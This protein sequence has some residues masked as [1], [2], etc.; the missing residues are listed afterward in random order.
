[1]ASSHLV[2]RACRIRVVSTP[3]AIELLEARCPI[4]EFELTS[5]PGASSAL[6][7]RLFDL[8]PLS[9]PQPHLLRDG[10]AS[11]PDLRSW[12]EAGPAPAAHS[13]RPPARPS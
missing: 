3:A 5:A 4:C 8:A 13:T 10:G 7:F 6:G 2:C 9:E 1:M 12:G 11:P